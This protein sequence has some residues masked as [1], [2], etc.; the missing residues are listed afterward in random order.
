MKQQ[1]RRERKLMRLKFKHE[2]WKAMQ[3]DSRKEKLERFAKSLKESFG[4]F[5]AGR[6]PWED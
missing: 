5:K 1:E 3:E 6:K 4:E 2:H